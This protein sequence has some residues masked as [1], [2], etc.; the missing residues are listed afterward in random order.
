MTNECYVT[1]CPI[2]KACEI[3]EPRWTLLILCELWNGS[4]HFN[5]IRRGVPAISPT[6]LSKRLRELERHGLVTRK[7]DKASGG[8]TY[9]VTSIAR[10]L[11]PIIEKLG[12]W[13][14][15]NVDTEVKLERLDARVLMWNM[16]RKVNTAVLPRTRRCVIQFIYPALPQG[17]RDYWIVSRP[18]FPIDMC[19]ID[20]G[21]DVDLYVT[22]DLKAMTSAWMGYSSLQS[23]IDKGHITLTGNVALINS[24]GN[25]MVRS[26]YAA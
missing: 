15:R 22:A 21:H 7:P 20:P 10:E 11:E 13:A 3:L 17:Q 1:F 18:G 19:M 6:L 14:H 4:T 24:I 23:Q 26:R 2:A 9:H 12:D 5:D 25:W 8:M 16:R